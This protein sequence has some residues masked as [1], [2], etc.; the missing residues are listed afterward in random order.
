MLLRTAPLF[1]RLWVGQFVSTIGDGMQRI[2]LL[3]WA[4]HHGGNG[5]LIAVALATMLPT[6][7]CSPITSTGAACS[8]APTWPDSASPPCWH[9]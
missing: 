3:W 8:S 7:V 2:A 5:L 9:R 6:I 4:K 1:R